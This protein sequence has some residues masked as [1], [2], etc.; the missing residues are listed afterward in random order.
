MILDEKMLV[1]ITKANIYHYIKF[2]P[3]IKIRDVIEIDISLH[4]QKGSNKKINVKCDICDTTR[5]INYQSYV[6]NITSCEKYP[7]YTC[8]KCSHI[9]SKEYNLQKY[10]VEYYS[11]HPDKNKKVKKTCLE[12]YGVEHFSKTSQFKEKIEKTNIKKF[13]FT[14]P[15]MDS[16]RI[17]ELFKKKYGVYHPSQV[18]EFK[19]KIENT[20]LEKYGYKYVLQCKEIKDKVFNTNLKKYGGHPMRSENVRNLKYIIS[21]DKDYLLYKGDNISIFK[22]VDNHNFEITSDLYHN[23]LRSNLPL[24]TICYPLKENVSIKEIELFKY[25]KSIYDGPVIQ[26]YRDNIEIDIYLP[27]LKI[28]FEFNGLYWHSNSQKGNRYHLDKTNFFSERGIK[29]IHIW[30]DDWD[31]KK[32]IIKSQISNS[33]TLSTKIHARKCQVVEIVDTKSIKSFLNNNHIQGYTNSIK[34]YGLVYNNE[35]VSIMTFDK[36]EG[37]KKMLE[38]EWNL[39]R[40]CNKLNTNIIGGASRLLSHFL[41]ETNPTR[42][43]SYADKDWSNGNLYYK[44]GFEKI[45]S[46]NPDYKYIIEGRRIHKSRYRKSRLNTNLSESQFMKKQGIDKIYD[47][48]KIKFELLIN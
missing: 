25:I 37:R 19:E 20:N 33:F 21:N 22:C 47:C 34:R 43:I 23:R 32:D 9:K 11:Q 27:E 36:S 42:I 24:C 14:N 3:F 44:L 17:K 29:I 7:I 6:I 15:F 13:G 28:G 30:E 38:N 12:R 26:N 48:G 18:P 40:Y 16:E 5:F 10:G 4:L 8:D 2:F 41:K 31:Y 39:N 46:T 1:K 45:S 35:L